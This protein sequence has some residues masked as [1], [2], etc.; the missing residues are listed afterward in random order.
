MPWFC[1]WLESY[2]GETA[3]LNDNAT[4]AEK[5]EFMGNETFKKR[6]K[7]L[8]RRLKQQQKAARLKERRD[9]RRITDSK[10]QQEEPK[11]AESVFR[12]EA[13]GSAV[14]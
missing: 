12:A 13:K 11:T 2:G 3:E 14:F 10:V 9:E 7:E 8:A 4:A 1:A 5:G 6:Q